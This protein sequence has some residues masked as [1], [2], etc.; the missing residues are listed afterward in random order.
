M[1][2]VNKKALDDWLWKHRYNTCIGIKDSLVD[3]S[4]LL[5]NTAWQDTVTNE[6]IAIKYA[7][8]ETTEEYWITGFSK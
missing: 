1:I 2:I 3:E 5:V 7:Q 6:K 4:N 8:S